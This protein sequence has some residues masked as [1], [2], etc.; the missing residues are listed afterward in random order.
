MRGISWLAE[1][2]LA[3][4]KHGVSG[5]SDNLNVKPSP[6]V[7]YNVFH[8][9]VPCSYERDRIDISTFRTWLPSIE[10]QENQAVLPDH[11][12]TLCRS[13]VISV[14]SAAILI[15]LLLSA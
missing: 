7:V 4:Q 5:R 6:E 2:R 8:Q 1:N 9:N 12:Y 13:V 11:K 3:S 15:C 14:Y 10:E